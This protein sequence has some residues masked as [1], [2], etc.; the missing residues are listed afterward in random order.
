MA[1]L[2]LVD[3]GDGNLET[4]M[5][6]TV[7]LQTMHQFIKLSR[8]LPER[9]VIK[10]VAGANVLFSWT[11]MAYEELGAANAE[12]LQA[13]AVKTTEAGNDFGVALPTIWEENRANSTS[14]GDLPLI[15]IVHWYC[16]SCSRDPLE[17]EKRSRA[18]DATLSCLPVF[19]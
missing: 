2:I 3:A 1:G 18:G 11:A 5:A 9:G 15:V 17:L 13:M 10:V 8:P 19:Q 4:Y 14:F 16:K 12:T 7:Y 6:D